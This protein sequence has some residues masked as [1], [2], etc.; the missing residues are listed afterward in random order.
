MSKRVT[1]ERSTTPHITYVIVTPGQRLR[2]ACK[3]ARHERQRHHNHVEPTV[4][5]RKQA[6]SEYQSVHAS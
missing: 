1:G 6:A 5:E 4:C 2:T 3:C